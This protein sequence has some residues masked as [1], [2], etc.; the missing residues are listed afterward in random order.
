MV[1][2]T[3]VARP[4]S[5]RSSAKLLKT[6]SP[7]G[8]CATLTSSQTSLS[9]EDGNDC[10][11]YQVA[12][13]DY[14]DEEVQRLQQ[15]GDLQQIVGSQSMLSQELPRPSQIDYE[16]GE[17]DV[18]KEARS[19]LVS[20]HDV[21][22]HWRKLKTEDQHSLAKQDRT[23]DK[24]HGQTSKDDI[25]SVLLSLPSIQPDANYDEGMMMGL[26]AMKHAASNHLSKSKHIEFKQDRQD[27]REK[28]KN[29]DDVNAKDEDPPLSQTSFGSLLDAIQMINE[30]DHQEATESTDQ[31]SQA[32]C[33]L[34]SSNTRPKRRRVAPK[35]KHLESSSNFQLATKSPR[36]KAKVSDS[37]KLQ[38]PM[39][40]AK[41]ASSAKAI[42]SPSSSVTPKSR[43]EV[44]KYVFPRGKPEY[45]QHTNAE[46]SKT[47]ARFPSSSATVHVHDAAELATKI[48]HDSELAKELLLSMALC[49]TNPRTPPESIPGPGH[50][51]PDGFFWSRYPP[52]ESVL[53]DYMPEYYRLSIEK[54]QSC[55]QQAFN[56]RL[57]DEVTA[58]A[59][60]R[61]WEFDPDHFTDVKVLRDRIRCYYKTHIQNA[62]KRLKTMLRNPTKRS[63]AIHL[64]EHYDLIQQAAQ[65]KLE[66][67]EANTP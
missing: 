54:C 7:P 63:N 66:A 64:K 52:L 45:L 50:V 4:V 59:H 36:K 2:I 25:A 51:L 9:N 55:Q 62:K 40:N 34:L 18:V 57:V 35:N 48:I 17:E 15:S 20:S 47:V 42:D 27:M 8:S 12:D 53:K 19:S 46:S 32:E 31:T 44:A 67:D 24:L 60:S 30:Q 16:Y 49:R 5:S 37:R 39:T 41:G 1:S 28:K 21:A 56:N 65:K 3:T 14:E 38:L 22:G 11:A 23:S 33:T 29:V 10:N 43:L 58:T 13:T 26:D 6:E 61:G